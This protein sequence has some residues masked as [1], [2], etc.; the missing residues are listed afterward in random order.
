MALAIHSIPSYNPKPVNAE[1]LTLE[2]I[3]YNYIAHG[4]FLI[5]VNYKYSAMSLSDIA[6]CIS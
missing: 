6:P 5:S 4:L 2:K 1:H 3:I